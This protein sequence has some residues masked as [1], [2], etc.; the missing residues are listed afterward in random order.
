MRVLVSGR[1]QGVFFRDS[2]R[3]EASLRGV[4]GWARN[5]ADGRVEVALEGDAAAVDLVVAWCR[6]GPP[7]ADV[8]G[9]EVSGEP[10]TGERGFAVLVDYGGGPC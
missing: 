10:P 5:L 7:R 1:V 6:R 9:I 2:L 4:A 3:T 8:T